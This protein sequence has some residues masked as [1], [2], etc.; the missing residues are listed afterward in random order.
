MILWA[1]AAPAIVNVR[2]PSWFCRPAV[3]SASRKQEDR[4]V[5][6]LAGDDDFGKTTVSGSRSASVWSQDSKL[7]VADSCPHIITT[8]YLSECFSPKCWNGGSIA[9]R[10]PIARFLAGNPNSIGS[11]RE[12]FLRASMMANFCRLVTL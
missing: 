10:N 11:H 6:V 5:L 8:R 4:G 1:Q 9:N 3:A 12:P 7:H 2:C